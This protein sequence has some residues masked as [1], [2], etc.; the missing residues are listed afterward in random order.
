[1]K[2]TKK[3]SIK[4]NPNMSREEFEKAVDYEEE[5]LDLCDGTMSLTNKD[6]AQHFYELGLKH[7][8]ETNHF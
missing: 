3:N 1:M 2:K 5:M 8:K 7:G 4:T 6:I